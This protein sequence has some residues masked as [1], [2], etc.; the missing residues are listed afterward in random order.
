MELVDVAVFAV[1][2]FAKWVRQTAMCSLPLHPLA[3]LCSL[4]IVWH[5]H[6]LFASAV[7]PD[8]YSGLANTSV[9][10]WLSFFFSFV[11]LV[12]F[13]GSFSAFIFNST[14]ETKETE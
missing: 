9:M 7:E 6:L 4:L 10:I 12:F 13:W 2:S 5:I 3:A 8:R 14:V 1:C 11:L